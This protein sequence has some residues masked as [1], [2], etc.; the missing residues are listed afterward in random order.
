MEIKK[1]TEKEALQETIKMYAWFAE[2]GD[3]FKESYFRE[4]N[5]KVKDVPL[6]YCYCCEYR[7]Q[8]NDNVNCSCCPVWTG[9]TSSK[10]G[11]HAP[12]SPYRKWFEAQTS[13]ERKR[14]AQE[15]ADLAKEKLAELEDRENG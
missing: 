8:N 1:L 4:N 9:A 13:E 6:A 14:Y 7:R 11:C 12:S 3:V 2:T 15:I 10:D 5:I